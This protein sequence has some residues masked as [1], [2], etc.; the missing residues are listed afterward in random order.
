LFLKNVYL[1]ILFLFLKKNQSL[2][3]ITRSLSNDSKE[4]S[5]IRIKQDLKISTQI[6]LQE[7][8]SQPQSPHKIDQE[9]NNLI[10]NEILSSST[11]AQIL[12]VIYEERICAQ[13][14]KYLLQNLQDVTHS[15]DVRL[16]IIDPKLKK[17]CLKGFNLIFPI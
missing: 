6:D 14:L 2:A 17:L 9:N 15:E 8:Q 5:P 12:K 10:K 13:T 11:S 16:F 3:K 1:F 7:V 4:K